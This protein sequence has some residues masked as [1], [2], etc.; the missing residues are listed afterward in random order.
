M[1]AFRQLNDVRKPNQSNSPT[2]NGVLFNHH[3]A[4][5]KGYKLRVQGSENYNEKK[6]RVQ[7][8]PN[9]R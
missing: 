4:H 6:K 9:E 3:T 7:E 1:V 2:E 8:A 5:V